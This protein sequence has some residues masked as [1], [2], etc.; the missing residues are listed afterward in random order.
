MLSA[1][2]RKCKIDKRD[3]HRELRNGHRKVMKKYFVK[4]MGT[5]KVLLYIID[6]KIIHNILTYI[7]IHVFLGGWNFYILSVIKF[8]HS[9]TLDYGIT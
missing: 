8:S 6:Q 7:Y 9:N 4:S 1:N 3:G 2:L 5:L